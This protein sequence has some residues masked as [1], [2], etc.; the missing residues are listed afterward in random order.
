MNRRKQLLLG[1]LISISTALEAQQLPILT[2][3]QVNSYLLN[4]AYAGSSD[5]AN[6]FLHTRRVWTAMP[7]APQQYFLT[8]DGSMNN[9]KIGVGLTTYSTIE[10]VIKNFGALL[11]YRYKIHIAA[12]HFLSGGLSAG[13]VQ[14]SLDFNKVSVMNPEELSEF[15]GGRSKLNFDF[16]AGLLYQFPNLDVGLTV[17][18]LTNT[19][20]A[21][22]QTTS[23]QSLAYRLIRHYEFLA[24]Y[25]W[26]INDNFTLKPLFVVQSSEGLPFHFML[27]ACMNYLDKYWIGIGY[28]LQAAYS[29]IVGLTVSDR[30]VIGYN[31]DI[32]ANGYHSQFGATHEIT[33][34]YRF[35]RQ[36]K[37]YT[38][39]ENISHNNIRQ[40]Q[41]MT[42]RQS[43]EIDKLKQSN[44]AL[45]K[46]V[47]QQESLYNSR[48]AEQ[49]QL[50]EINARK[51]AFMDSLRQV[52]SVNPDSMANT[53]QRKIYVVLGAYSRIPDAKIFQRILEREAGLETRIV[54]STDGKYY[55]VYSTI[56]LSKA[57]A[58]AELMRL[59]DMDIQ[60]YLN[61]NAWFYSDKTE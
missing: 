44:E 19:P 27:N 16:N 51:H 37:K 17:R 58:N 14:N 25:H 31:Y 11:T 59:T 24:A 57:E 8:A 60:K 38:P 43:E 18:Q 28:K 21:Y 5:W 6:I 12:H 10:P 39:S 33:V 29:A 3:S 30:L 56:V 13:F 7:G 61:G 41:E 47:E 45:Q 26:V 22:E 9:P 23:N 46:R 40:L 32:P 48:D 50:H 35:A 42:Q 49:Q 20:Y 55:F 53:S 1:A 4:P 54:P 15:Q 36:S 34:G 52:Y 2:Q